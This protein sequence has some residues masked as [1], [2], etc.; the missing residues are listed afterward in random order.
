MINTFTLQFPF[1]CR[2]TSQTS[3]QSKRN[4][5]PWLELV[6]EQKTIGVTV[7]WTCC[8]RIQWGESRVCI[9]QD[10]VGRVVTHKPVVPFLMWL[11]FEDTSKL[12]SFCAAL[13]FIWVYKPN[14]I[15]SLSNNCLEI[16]YMCIET[17]FF[18]TN[19]SS[20][21]LQK[22]SSVIKS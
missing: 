8:V 7:P 12:N 18:E 22:Y 16:F 14:F 3:I 10:G 19:M 4:I 17:G 20:E 6:T 15:P 1:C 13:A 2:N 21:T 11:F 9:A 5:A